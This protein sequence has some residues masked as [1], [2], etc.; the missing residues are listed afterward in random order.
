M[1]SIRDLNTASKYGKLLAFC[2]TQ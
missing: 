1:V 2:I